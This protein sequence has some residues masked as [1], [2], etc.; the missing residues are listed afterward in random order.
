MPNT[1]RARFLHVPFFALGFHNASGSVCRVWIAFNGEWWAAPLLHPG[2]TLLPIPI[3]EAFQVDWKVISQ[4]AI[5]HCNR[6]RPGLYDS[7]VEEILS[8]DRLIRWQ[9]SFCCERAQ[10]GRGMKVALL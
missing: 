3:L 5:D 6:L 7:E 10:L 1:Y 4:T 9:G 8:E 2:Q